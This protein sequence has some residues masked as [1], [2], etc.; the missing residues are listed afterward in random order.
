MNNHHLTQEE[1]E[2]REMCLERLQKAA[3]ALEPIIFE[4]EKRIAE[5]KNHRSMFKRFF[6]WMF[7]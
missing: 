3:D 6:H 7:P 4:L 2:Q 1:R 5:K